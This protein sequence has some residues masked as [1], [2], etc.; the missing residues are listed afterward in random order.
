[1]KENL[2]VKLSLL[3]GSFSNEPAEKNA[4][5]NRLFDEGYS[6]DPFPQKILDMRNKGRLLYR[7][8]I[9]VPDYDPLKLRILQLYHDAPSTG[10]PGCEKTF[11]LISRDYH[12]PFIWNYIAR[13][14]RNCHT[15]QRSKPNTHGKLGV[16]RLL[17]IPEQ[18]WQEVSM[19]F[20]TSLP[21]SEGYDAIMVVVDRL[22][23]MRNLLPCN[24]TVNSED[25]AQL[26]LG[27]IWKLHGLPTHV[28]SDRGTQFTAK[29]WRALCKH[30]K[31]EARMSTAFH[32]ET[33]GQT[34]RL[35]AL[36]MA[37]FSCNNQVSASTKATPLFANY[38]FHHRFTVIIK[39]L[40]R[41]PSSL[42]VKDFA[43]KMKELHE[44]LRSNICTAQDQQEQAINTKRTPAPQY[45]I[46][47][48]VFVST[49]NIR[50]TRNSRKLDWKK[51]GVFSVTEII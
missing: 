25:V 50:T 46:G 21:E 9:Y 37:E 16:L 36:P 28:T 51:L 43:L 1:M 34:E 6:A 26:Y 41:T 22:T 13:Y 2:D 20:I 44:H 4:S 11:E 7:G 38:G 17:P 45:N 10:H 32:P 27:N 5:L 19:D 23:K 35:N 48:M 29:F 31:I 33:D 24:T 47:D 14:V 12:W 49:K 3:V 15:C 40:D 30:L 42:N 18:P 8:S 39:S